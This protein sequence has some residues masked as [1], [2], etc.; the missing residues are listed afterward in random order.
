[1][2][3]VFLFSKPFIETEGGVESVTVRLANSLRNIGVCCYFLTH[4]G[5]KSN[6]D[7]KFIFEFPSSDKFSSV[8]RT[9]LIDF[10][11]N[12]EITIVINQ[13]AMYPDFCNF[14]FDADLEVPIIS[15]V[16]GDPL[17]AIRLYLP[18]LKFKLF[19]WTCDFKCFRNFV[20]RILLFAYKI[21][22]RSHYVRLVG[23]SYKTV[24]LSNYYIEDIKKFSNLIS[25]DKLCVIQNS[26]DKK[27]GY[28][29]VKNK[30]NELLY[31]GRMVSNPKRVEFL[32]R[33]WKL[34]SYELPDWKFKLVGS[35]PD[36][37]RFKRI[38][39]KEN[40]PNIEFFLSQDPV[41]FYQKASIFCFASCHEGF[42]L[43]IVEAMSHGVVPVAVNSYKLLSDIITDNIDGILVDGYDLNK[44]KAAIK[45]LAIDVARRKKMQELAIIKSQKFTQKVI[46]KKWCNLLFN[47]KE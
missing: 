10:I 47:I 41:P 8:N 17:G 44:Y 40:I 5:E 42:G 30:E 29:D 32:I 25:D 43:V 22:Y 14:L 11:V 36:L 19:N 45:N 3:I 18:P 13:S 6:C 28:L 7:N 34:L 2:N 24:L 16:H 1:M 15:C 12:K 33:M 26:Y 35:G 38:V 9:F 37:E 46:L 21:K 20:Y 27:D 23:K 31:V 4:K 39:E